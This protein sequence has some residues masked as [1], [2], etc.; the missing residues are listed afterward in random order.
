MESRREHLWHLLQIGMDSTSVPLTAVDLPKGSDAVAASLPTKSKP[1]SKAKRTRRKSVSSTLGETS[2]APNETSIE[3]EPQKKT[4]RRKTKQE[5]AMIEQKTPD[6]AATPQQLDLTS[7][8]SNQRVGRRKPK[9]DPV[10][11]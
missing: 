8:K 3:P 2:T 4:T 6:D 9:R 7:K 1:P 5:D 11:E 10:G